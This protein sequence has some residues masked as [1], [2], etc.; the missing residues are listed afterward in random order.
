M[1]MRS[2]A[3]FLGN[4]R[5]HVHTEGRT[6]PR[7]HQQRDFQETG[8]ITYILRA[9]RARPREGQRRDFRQTDKITY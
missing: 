6:R 5:D 8:K 7:E 9:K 1:E 2:A 3:G 4:R